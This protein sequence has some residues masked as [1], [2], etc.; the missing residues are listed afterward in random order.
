MA[1]VLAAL[2]GPLR[3]S[4]NA[5]RRQVTSPLS[6]TGPGVRTNSVNA[7]T[8]TF[9][10]T[11]QI[12]ATRGWNQNTGAGQG[13]GRWLIER[14]SFTRTLTALGPVNMTPVK[15]RCATK[16]ALR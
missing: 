11:L 13:D 5:L 10:Q 4:A 9:A 12:D 2:N 3:R 16:N 15:M 14:E 7:I 1:A 6:V 8:V